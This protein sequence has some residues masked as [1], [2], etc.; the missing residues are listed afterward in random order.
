MADKNTV[1]L[2]LNEYHNLRDM[3]FRTFV[4]N[5][6]YEKYKEYLDKEKWDLAQYY[7]YWDEQVGK[8]VNEINDKQSKLKKLERSVEAKEMKLDSL[9]KNADIKKEEIKYF[10]EKMKYSN[11]I[12]YIIIVILLVWNMIQFFN[13]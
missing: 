3:N 11:T 7:V 13:F 2:D 8:K 9:N 6:S 10:E 4:E 5:L 12:F 1:V